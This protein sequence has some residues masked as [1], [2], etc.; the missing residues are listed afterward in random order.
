P[1]EVK[2]PIEK[3]GISEHGPAPIAN[4]PVP[5]PLAQRP[6][7]P[8]VIRKV[9]EG[10]NLFRLTMSVYGRA[11]NKLVAWVQQNNPWI[12]D[13]NIIPTGKE[14]VFPEYKEKE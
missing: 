7:V 4:R 14:I 13:I 10:D 3:P 12:K 11:D 8:P 5:A 1:S 6:A 9:K 2:P